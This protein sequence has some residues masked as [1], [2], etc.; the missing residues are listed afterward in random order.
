M[1]NF[2][3]GQVTPDMWVLLMVQSLRVLLTLSPR[4]KTLRWGTYLFFNVLTSCA[5]TFFWLFVPKTKQLMPE[6]M[7]FVFGCKSTAIAD[8]EKMR[9]INTEIGLDELLHGSAPETMKDVVDA[10]INKSE[11]LEKRSKRVP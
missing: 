11:H 3:V 9:R 10:A 2:I 7:D 6:E 1:N 5:A 8:F 4:L